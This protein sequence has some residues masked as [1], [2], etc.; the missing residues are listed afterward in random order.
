VIDPPP[1]REGS[2]WDRMRRRKVVQWGVAY[3]AAAWVALQVLE[4]LSETF[5]WPEQL[6]PLSTLGLMLGLPVVVTIAWYH[7]DRGEQRVS[8]AELLILSLLL[9]LVAGI[10]WRYAFMI[11]MRE[12][13]SA[14]TT[15]ATPAAAH[16]PA[17]P[18][19]SVAVLP[20]VNIGADK[21]QEYFSDGLTEELLALL[22]RVPGIYVPARTSS[23]YFKGKQT[24]VHEIARALNVAYVL[25]GSVRKSGRELRITAQLSRAD[26]GYHVWS[27]SYDRELRDIFGTQDEIANG[28][29]QALKVT[30]LKPLAPGGART[31]SPEAHELYLQ[32]LAI[33]QGDG[34]GDYLAA[35]EHLKRALALDPNYASAWAARAVVAISD[36]GWHGS[37]EYRTPCER[38]RE[39][40]ER[41]LQLEP[42]L[43]LAH[44]AKAEIL[45]TCDWNWTAAETELKHAL[46][47]DPNNVGALRNYSY[48]TRMQRRA[49]EAVMFARLAVERDP[50]DAWAHIL[51]GWALG[52]K[53][54]FAAAEDSYRRALE[55]D[56]TAAG[57]H[58]LLANALLARHRAQAA[59]AE[60]EKE[61][62]EQFRQMNR[63]FVLEALGR[64]ADADRELHTF[65]V[66]YAALDPGT[67]AEFYACR[68]DTGRA[69][70]WSETALAQHFLLDDVP[71]RLACLQKLAS[72]PRYQTLLRKM[73]LPG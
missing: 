9:T 68:H 10:L 26:T 73:G 62:D 1:Q 33:S 52:A 67:M 27:Q 34:P 22:T 13:T 56:P 30:L 25:E 3:A 23:F 6:R 58:A 65:E 18:P 38:G 72:E 48:I 19:A 11:E 2:A 32:A 15:A 49:D 39:A 24:T 69:L 60:N 17:P 40:A 63:P 35:E 61:S 36:V 59:M 42:S 50:L 31:S 4:Y 64:H 44:F 21:D 7:G 12:P 46:A 5:H 71:N 8:R 37:A 70:D 53:G 55:L 45:G 66:Q 16:P 43:A 54:Q 47:L 20:F 29:V 14:P 41:A 28:V 57:R 51:L